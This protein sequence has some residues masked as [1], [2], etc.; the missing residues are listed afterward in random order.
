[1]GGV[2]FNRALLEID[3]PS[4]SSAEIA[5]FF[6]PIRIPGWRSTTHDL[7]NE[8]LFEPLQGATSGR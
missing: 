6:R 8:K 5:E 2:S 4:V 1:M 3:P 7:T